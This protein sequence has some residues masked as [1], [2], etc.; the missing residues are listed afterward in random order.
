M[1]PIWI[2]LILHLDYFTLYDFSVTYNIFMIYQA[3]KC[4]FVMLFNA[5]MFLQ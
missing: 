1:W 5:L 4:Q 3:Y 2:F